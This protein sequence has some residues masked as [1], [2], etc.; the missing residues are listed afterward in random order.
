MGDDVTKG[1]ATGAFSSWAKTVGTAVFGTLFGAASTIIV[2]TTGFW[3]KDR[4]MDI[5]MVKLALTMLSDPKN[6]NDDREGQRVFALNL[7]Q[8]FSGVP[9]DEDDE[10]NWRSSNFVKVFPTAQDACAESVSNVMD[11]LNVENFEKYWIAGC[12]T[13]INYEQFNEL[14]DYLQPPSVPKEQIMVDLNLSEDERKE[15]AELEAELLRSKKDT[16]I[17]ELRRAVDLKKSILNSSAPT[18]I[19]SAP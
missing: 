12:A 18:L 6:M 14:K 15:I 3:S 11:D 19:Q 5:E 13:H 4:E 8:K 16:F 10:R 2:A 9:V 7:L 1:Q 17:R